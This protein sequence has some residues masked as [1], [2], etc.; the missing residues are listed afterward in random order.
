MPSRSSG[1]PVRVCLLSSTWARA[2]V[3]VFLPFR[4]ARIGKVRTAHL[5]MRRCQVP[6]VDAEGL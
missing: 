5:T 4:K 6:P 1:C 2:L 3:V